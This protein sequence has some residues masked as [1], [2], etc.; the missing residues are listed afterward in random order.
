MSDERRTTA[1]AL[2]G[3]PAGW[4]AT[5]RDLLRYLRSESPPREAAVEW[6]REEAAAT[7]PDAA[8]DQLAFLEEI[9]VVET[10]SGTARPGPRGREF[11]D[12]H[13]EGVLFEALTGSVGGFETLLESLAVRPLTDVEF[14]D[15]LERE[16]DADLGST[17]PVLA[18]RRW[19]AA[20]GYLEHDDGVNDLTRTGRRRV[21][22]DDDL[23]PPRANRPTGTGK[24]R[25]DTA[26]REAGTEPG[27]GPTEQRGGADPTE[28]PAG[29]EPVESADSVE[30]TEPVERDD[31][32][33][34]EPAGSTTDGEFAGLKRRYDHTCMVCGDRRRRTP[35]EGLARVHHP[36]PTDEDHGGPAEPSNAVVVCPNHEA[37]FAC[38]LLTVDPRTR[39]IDHAYEPEVSGRTLATADGHDVGAQ[40][41]AYH[42]EVVA[43]F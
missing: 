18:H 34:S 37:D 30:P 3:E 42:N 12:T 40:Y 6:L 29:A 35:D 27:S 8:A 16:F 14:R 20:I 22:T 43:D 25:D 9:G 26:G 21:E 23:T 7:G 39:T 17:E 33:A 32:T 38:G 41:L 36:M 4:R 13:D 19:L 15:L 10:D 5:T 2:P 28:A 31:S 11:L 24:D 1:V